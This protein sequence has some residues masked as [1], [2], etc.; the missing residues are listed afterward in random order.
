[1][2]YT[3]NLNP[4]DESDPYCVLTA[5]ILPTYQGHQGTEMEVALIPIKSNKHL[6]TGFT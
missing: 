4:A 1:M 2:N 3:L 5:N 6:K